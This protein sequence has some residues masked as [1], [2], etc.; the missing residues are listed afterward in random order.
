MAR[1]AVFGT[2]ALL[3]VV[4]V[5]FVHTLRAQGK[6]FDGD[7]WMASTAAEQ[8]G[9][10]LGYGD[11]FADPDSLRVH[12]LMDDAA[13]RTAISDYYQSHAAQHGRP[14]PEVLKEIW[15]G[16]I[17]VRGAEKAQAGQGWRARH[18]FFDGGWWKGSNAAERLGFVEGYITCVNNGK[19]KAAHLQLS[20]SAYV[21]WVDVWYAGNGDQEVSAER[22]GVKVDDVLLRVGN[23]PIPGAR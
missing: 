22:Q 12:M 1:H 20:P 16:H 6:A 9:F 5:G 17:A 19:N 14:A 4:I 8:E 11:C 10:V 13:L 21:Q 15:S 7:W 2:S 23:A 3:I 18:G